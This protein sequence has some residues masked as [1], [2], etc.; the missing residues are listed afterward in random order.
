MDLNVKHSGI[1]IIL[2]LIEVLVADGNVFNVISGKSNKTWS[3][4]A[5]F[6]LFFLFARNS[7]LDRSC[8]NRLSPM[9]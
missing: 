8:N 2:H 7:H 1:F 5:I 6:Y 3:I 4:L 9:Q